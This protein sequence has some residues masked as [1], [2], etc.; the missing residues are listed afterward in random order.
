MGARELVD[1]ELWVMMDGKQV[2]PGEILDIRIHTLQLTSSAAWTFIREV[3]R[4]SDT[5]HPPLLHKL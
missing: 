5:I 1:V 4:R 2:Q 3:D